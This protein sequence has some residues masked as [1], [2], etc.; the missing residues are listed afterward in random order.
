M[1]VSSFICEQYI[2]ECGF[3]PVFERMGYLYV[4]ILLAID[5]FRSRNAY[6]VYV[7]KYRTKIL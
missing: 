4:Y 5:S 1:K 6:T 3:S 2:L 7:K